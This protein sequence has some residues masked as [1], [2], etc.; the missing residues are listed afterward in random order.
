MSN[1][2]TEASKDDPPVV[3]TK[4]HFKRTP[5]ESSNC[6]KRRKTAHENHIPSTNGTTTPKTKRQPDFDFTHDDDIPLPKVSKVFWPD[7]Y[8]FKDAL[9]ASLSDPDDARHWAQIFGSEI[10]I[11]PRPR[12]MMT[13]DE[14]ATWVREQVYGHVLRESQ[15]K[16]TEEAKR[17]R[18]KQDAKIRQMREER[19]RKE[20]ERRRKEEQDW[21]KYF[22]ERLNN[23]STRHSHNSH[24]SDSGYRNLRSQAPL[25]RWKDYLAAFQPPPPDANLD[26]LLLWQQSDVPWPTP[27]GLEDDISEE[28]VRMFIKTYTMKYSEQAAGDWKKAVRLNQYYWHP[29]KFRQ[30][31]ARK[32]EKLTMEKKEEIM[33]RVTAVSQILNKLAKE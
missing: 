19:E 11:Y 20:Y 24:T 2:K 25:Q 15:Q 32:L 17:E 18:L 13:D 16:K 22:Q 12:P 26:L 9:F 4:L 3:K 14:Y 8:S 29:D 30:I 31:Q 27:S 33:A 5:S 1:T 7:R 28:N 10:H 6:S 23:A 21:Q